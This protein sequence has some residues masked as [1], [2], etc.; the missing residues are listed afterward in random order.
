MFTTTRAKLLG[1]TLVAVGILTYFMVSRN[2][3]SVL[4]C[5][6]VGGGVFCMLANRADFGVFFITVTGISLDRF[7]T[8]FPKENWSRLIPVS[9]YH[10]NLGFTSPD[11]RTVGTVALCWDEVLGRWPLDDS[12]RIRCCYPGVFSWWG[13]GWYS[14]IVIMTLLLWRPRCWWWWW[15]CLIV[16]K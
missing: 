1:R 2:A 8:W 9:V 6:E 15:Y 11:Q 12:R 4:S 16:S 10:K 3:V 14:L 7:A 13:G 5:R